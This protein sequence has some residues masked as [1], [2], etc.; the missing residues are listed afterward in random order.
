MTKRS[1]ALVLAASL[2]LG[3]GFLLPLWRIDL[4]APQ[5]P[6]GIGV[7]IRVNTI[8]GRK[9]HDLSNLNGLNHYIG[10]KPIEPDSIPELRWMPWIL[11]GLV[12]LGLLT[13]ATRS[14]KLLFGWAGLFLLFAVAGLVDFYKWGYEYGHDLDPHA[15]IQV[16]GMTYQPPLIGSKK[17]LNFTSRSWPASGGWIALGALLM[18]VGVAVVEGKRGRG[19]NAI[20]ADASPAGRRPPDADAAVTG[21]G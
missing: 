17:L 5:Y 18:A 20:A 15:A 3:L 8:T 2:A 7:R 19:G 9:P 21:A 6:E 1:R 16:P 13:A 10:M 4:H 11:G 12:G 14:R